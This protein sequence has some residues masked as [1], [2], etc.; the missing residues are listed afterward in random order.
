M[1]GS[2]A[3]WEGSATDGGTYEWATFFTGVEDTQSECGCQFQIS[4]Q[5]SRSTVAGKLKNAF[6]M[7]NEGTGHS[8]KLVGIDKN[9]VEFTGG[10]VDY[11]TINL[12]GE[13]PVTVGTGTPTPVAG[14]T[15]QQVV[16]M[17]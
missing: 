17:H 7:A 6:N 13:S 11:M 8:A 1:A 3:S 2:D 12:Q 9:G 15:V 5:D 4:P 16:A 14:L 10:T